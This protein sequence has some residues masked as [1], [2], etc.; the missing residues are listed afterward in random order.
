MEEDIDME[1]IKKWTKPSLELPQPLKGNES[2]TFVGKTVNQRMPEI[3]IKMKDEA[4][5]DE[6]TNE[7]IQELIDSLPNGKIIPIDDAFA[8]DNQAWEEFVQPYLG[9]TWLEV[10]WFFAETY[11][12]RRILA[13]TGY[14]QSIDN[15]LVDPFSTQKLNGLIDA[16]PVFDE[17]ANLFDQELSKEK[18]LR[19]LLV[20]NLWGNKADLSFF[21][22]AGSGQKIEVDPDQMEA[23][24]VVNH[25]NPLMHF[26]K[27]GKKKRIDIIL[28]NVGVE[29]IS[30]IVLAY[31]MVKANFADQVVLHHKIHPTFVSDATVKDTRELI[32]QLGKKD[33]RANLFVTELFDFVEQE[34]II[35]MDH[36]YWT[37]P[38][39]FWEMPQQLN[40]YYL[41]SNLII[42]KGD[43]N[44]R[45][46][47]GD[48]HWEY[49]TKMEEVLNYCP[50]PLLT[51]R[52]CKS[53]EMI[54]LKKG[55]AE[56]LAS[57]DSKWLYNAQWGIM[58]FNNPQQK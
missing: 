33:E 12:Y 38:N 15:Y 35:L 58:M 11:F 4:F 34:K 55:Q 27:E 13:E 1:Q 7:R 54:G 3:A 20:L 41:E 8:P 22:A 14:Y 2:G 42:S 37:S 10:P 31:W 52:I 21:P 43:A 25:L 46:V 30:D 6:P 51:I 45:R 29:L 16:L 26:F 9:Q 19:T 50:V 47:L 44:Y 40:D 28:D 56:V 17:L 49:D 24:I 48:L 36:E 32:Y 5:F 23:K 39:P 57:I 18:I 53:E